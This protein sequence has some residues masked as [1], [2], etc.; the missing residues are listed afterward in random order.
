MAEDGADGVI[1]ELKEAI[2]RLRPTPSERGTA[3]G[4][5]DGTGGTDG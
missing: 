5:T 2:A 3:A 4:V 1:E